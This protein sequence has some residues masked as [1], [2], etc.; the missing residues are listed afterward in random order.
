M[1]KQE[2]SNKPDEE[3]KKILT[4][5]QFFVTR[6]SGTE[7]PFTGIYDD[8]YEKGMYKCICCGIELFESGTKFNSGCGWP[9]FFDMKDNKSIIHKEDNSLNRK[10]IELKCAHCDAHLGHVFEDGPQPTG[11][12]YCINSASLKFE[13]DTLE[14]NNDK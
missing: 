2:N 3:W 13:A 5:A 4:P 14:N 7:K 8:F 9:S 12:R 6:Q 11:L 10:R 1:E